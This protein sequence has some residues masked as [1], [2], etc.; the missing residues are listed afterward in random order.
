LIA[1]FLSGY[2]LCTMPSREPELVTCQD[3]GEAVSFSAAN[4]PHCGS[5]EPQ[6][7]YD[8]SRRERRRHRLE[9]RNDHTMMMAVLGCSALG[10]CYGAITAS[11]PLW[12]ILA[13][14]G[15]GSLGLLL[16]VPVAFVINMTR[17]L[18]R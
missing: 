10:A 3:C 2:K 12:K 8:H 15:Y 14:V 18:G 4:C 13:G 5:T 7:P 16:G 1:A 6:G 9:E 17:H 11:G